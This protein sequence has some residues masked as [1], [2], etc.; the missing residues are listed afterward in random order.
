M[1]P[2]LVKKIADLKKSKVGSEK[3]SVKYGGEMIVYI[4]T[5]TKRGN[6]PGQILDP[7]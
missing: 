1:Q 3:K 6:N 2:F 7:D 4:I 5:F